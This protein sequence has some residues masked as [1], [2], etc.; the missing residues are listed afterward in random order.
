MRE[1]LIYE[2]NEHNQKI[3]ISSS[4][5]EYRRGRNF[6]K[7]NSKKRRFSLAWSILISSLKNTN[8]FK[9]DKHFKTKCL[10]PLFKL[11]YE[12]HH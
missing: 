8:K 2:C 9:G 5:K 12:N 7:Y 11:L 4:R 3:L 6:I 1:T 10:S